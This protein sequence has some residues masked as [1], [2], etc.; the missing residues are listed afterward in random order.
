MRFVRSKHLLNRY[1]ILLLAVQPVS[2][3]S[4]Y[5]LIIEL[6]AQEGKE[7]A[8]QYDQ[9]SHAKT[10]VQGVYLLVD[11]PSIEDVHDRVMHDV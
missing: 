7:D 5:R 8:G 9:C 3:P 6:E 4:A 2:Q 1:S 10:V 11:E